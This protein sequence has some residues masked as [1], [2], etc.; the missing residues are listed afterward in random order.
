MDNHIGLYQLNATVKQ[1]LKQLFPECIW[2]VAE[3]ADLREHISGH[4]YLELVEKHDNKI[5]ASARATIWANVYRQLKNRF[6]KEVGRNLS[7][8]LKILI[9]VEVIFHEQYGFSLNI[10]NI[11]PKY[12]LGDILQAKQEILNRLKDEGILNMNKDLDFPKL[13][14]N[15]ALISSPTAAGLEDFMMQIE[16]NKYGY[17]FHIKLFPSIMQGDK[18][19]ESLIKS[20]ELI[21]KNEYLFDVVVIVRG[22][23]S[24]IDLA[25]FDTYEIGCNI[26]QFPLPIIVGIGHERDDTIVDLV[27]HTKL[28]TPTAVA[29]F[30]ICKFY[31]ADTV[32]CNLRDKFIDRI[33]SK[34]LEE[35]TSLQYTSKQIA[36]LSTN[37]V[38]TNKSKL[39]D[40]MADTKVRSNLRTLREEANLI[41]LE[42]TLKFNLR[43]KIKREKNIVDRLIMNL[44]IG[45]AGIIIKEKQKLEIASAISKHSDP[46]LILKRGF[47]I[48]RVGGKLVSGISELKKGDIME[49][50]LKDGKI[51]SEV[52]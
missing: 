49:T 13:P 52:I 3:I 16:N 42:N 51:K 14:K 25:S 19:T 24:K 6:E 33:N 44:S 17:K 48:S 41:R 40:F 4:C 37:L 27:A 11:D 50:T 1:G 5:I 21:Y 38:N 15:I 46:K 39:K 36:Y 23:G 29:E 34:I 10:K 20:L 28:K 43:E 45:S 31:E 35:K 30:L 9:A 12:T 2:I 22:G 7:A 47:S 8:G 26:A 18:T 32:L